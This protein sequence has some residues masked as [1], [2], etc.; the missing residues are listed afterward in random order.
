MS[1]PG[2]AEYFAETFEEILAWR[3]GSRSIDFLNLSLGVSGIIENYSEEVLREPFAELVDTMVQQDSDEKVIFVWAA[4]NY[5]GDKC[6][7]P[8]PQCIDGKV[9]ASSADILSALAV[10]FPELGENTVAVVA[11][12]PTAR[13]PTFPTAAA[14]R[15]TTAWRHRG[16]RFWCPISV[17]TRAKSAS[18][19]SRQ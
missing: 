2:T 11:I 12:R 3:F 19:L 13:S 15:P 4:G 16:M 1:L 6:D 17:R 7:I 10:R 14:S 9:E 5:N 18:E 8:I